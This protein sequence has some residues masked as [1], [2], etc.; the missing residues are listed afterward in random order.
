MSPFLS[1]ERLA[2]NLVLKPVADR[3]SRFS[4]SQC[5]AMMNLNRVIRLPTQ[6]N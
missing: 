1:Q 6:T 2:L 5:L 4:A 3:Q